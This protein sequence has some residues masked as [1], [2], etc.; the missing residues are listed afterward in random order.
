MII[1]SIS[2]EAQKLVLSKRRREGIRIEG[3][4]SCKAAEI[5]NRFRWTPKLERSS[6]QLR[7]WLK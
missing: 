4:G 1:I 7:G 3:A 2:K 6:N 5:I